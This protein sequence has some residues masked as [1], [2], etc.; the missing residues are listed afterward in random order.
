MSHDTLAML[1]WLMLGLS[2]ALTIAGVAARASWA[3]FFAAFLS[4]VFG[5]LAI[6]SIGIFILGLAVVQ[7]VLG[8]GIRRSDVNNQPQ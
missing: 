7:L 2:V 3:L 6:L 5:I 8:I 4:F 1:L